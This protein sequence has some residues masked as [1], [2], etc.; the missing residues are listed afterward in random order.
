L[1]IT[2]RNGAPVA[3]Y[4]YLPRLPGDQSV[5]VESSSEGLLI[6]YAPDGRAIGIE[7]TAPR[8][9]TLAAIN[10]ALATAH[11]LPAT[12]DDVAPLLKLAEPTR[13]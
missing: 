12:L 1:E 5:R 3:V 8:R 9:A 4:F 10:D 2:Y 13:S 11:Q 7:I 6:D